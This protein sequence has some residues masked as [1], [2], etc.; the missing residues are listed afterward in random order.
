[1][2]MVKLECVLLA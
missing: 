2:A 1:M